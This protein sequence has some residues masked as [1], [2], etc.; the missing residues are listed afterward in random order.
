MIR[1]I[2]ETCINI[3]AVALT[4]LL[5]EYGCLSDGIIQALKI[6]GTFSIIDVFPFLYYCF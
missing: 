5:K 4:W 3:N 6:E 2:T 1:C